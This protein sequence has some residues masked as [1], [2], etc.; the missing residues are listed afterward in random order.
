MRKI[1]NALRLI[2]AVFSV[3]EKRILFLALIIFILAFIANY[4][5]I[6]KFVPYHPERGGTYIEGVV[7][8]VKTLDPFEI[9]SQAELDVVSILFRKLF[10]LTSDG[11]IV[12]DLLEK[13]KISKDNK[14][15]S[16]TL[17]SN[18][19]WHDQKILTANDVLFTLKKFQNS[20][21][22]LF[23]P[24]PDYISFKKK[25]NQTVIIKSEKAINLLP[26]IGRLPIIPKHVSDFSQPIGSGPFQF[27][28]FT[29]QGVSLKSVSSLTYLENIVIKTYENEEVLFDAYNKREI[30][31]LGS[32][33]D[34]NYLELKN[35]KDLNV[36]SF[37]VPQYFA[38]FLNTKQLSLD[39]RKWISAAIDKQKILSSI[40][41]QGVIL[42]TIT[43]I[44]SKYAYKPL[45]D[46]PP[47]HSLNILTLSSIRHQ[48]I[49]KEIQ[50]QLKNFDILVNITVVS[51]SDLS[52]ILDKK[53][54]A[55]LISLYYGTDSELISPFYSGSQA[56]FSRILNPDLDSLLTSFTTTSVPSLKSRLLNSVY[57]VLRN[58]RS[59]V[60]LVRPAYSYVIPKTVKNVSPFNLQLPSDRFFGIENWYIKTGIK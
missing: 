49:A 17:K 19:L 41:D 37:S 29:D 36:F 26:I 46:S 21:S 56:N 18:L 28:Q 40:I 33:S 12:T 22:N 24:I 6:G 14:T 59:V 54:D 10:R 51:D 55:V 48:N 27:G 34:D 44:D 39:D 50:L 20:G 45:I 31:G 32:I 47:K 16:F 1:V 8:Q 3:L 13:Y 23:P 53:Y 43:G 57:G 15:F 9:T 4:F 7:G 38:L 11:K 35:H 5:H 52:N 60:F 2:W 25:D 58:V 30:M 42:K